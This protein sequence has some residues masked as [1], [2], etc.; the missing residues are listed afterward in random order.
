MTRRPIQ[1]ANPRKEDRSAIP[2]NTWDGTRSRFG[3]GHP[4]LPCPAQSLAL[5]RGDIP[6]K[7]LRA[8][9]L[10]EGQA[11]EGSRPLVP[12]VRTVVA[13]LYRR[14]HGASHHLQFARAGGFHDVSPAPG[15]LLPHHVQQ[16]ARPGDSRGRTLPGTVRMPRP[17]FSH[18]RSPDRSGNSCKHP[19]G[20]AQSQPPLQLPSA[21]TRLSP[22]PELVALHRPHHLTQLVHTGAAGAASR[23]PAAA[24]P[25]LPH[26]AVEVV[27]LICSPLALKDRCVGA[28]CVQ[29]PLGARACAQRCWR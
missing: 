14:D 12:A 10:P 11:G 26:L 24:R 25:A 22:V 18:R 1:P 3:E 21:Q 5:L 8:L 19:P 2:L 7:R 16:H 27:E 23:A 20:R 15:T 17:A 9:Q 28:R 4:R 6:L 13:S 29:A